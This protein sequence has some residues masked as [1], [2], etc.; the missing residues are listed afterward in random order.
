MCCLFPFLA[1]LASAELKLWGLGR[2]GGGKIIFPFFCPC[3]EKLLC[4]SHLCAA[5]G[6]LQGAGRERI[7]LE[8]KPAQGDSEPRF[9][10]AVGSLEVTL[11]GQ[12]TYSLS[13][14]FVQGPVL[15]YILGL[16]VDLALGQQETLVS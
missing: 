2:G 9:S 15:P 8:V 10:Y 1:S 5:C 3:Q 13:H 12:T 11:V 4:V 7:L 14:M 16:G 6:R